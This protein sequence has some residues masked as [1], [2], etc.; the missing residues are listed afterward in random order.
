MIGKQWNNMNVT[1]YGS[2]LDLLVTTETPLTTYTWAEVVVICVVVVSLILV[3]IAGNAVVVCLV[4]INRR[5]RPVQNLFIAS[6]AVSDLCVG[7]L[8]MPLS[9]ANELMGYW[10]FGTVLCELWLAFDVLSCTASILNLCLISVDRYLCITRAMTYPRWRDKNKCVIMIGV[11][12]L[13]AMLICLPPLAGWKRPQP[14]KN[15]LPLCVL[16]SEVGYIIYSTLGSF[17]IP[18]IVM[19]S[20]YIRI[21]LAVKHQVRRRFS[22]RYDIPQ[23]P[24]HGLPQQEEIRR[25]IP[26]NE[27]CEK[28]EPMEQHE[29]EE[30]E[31]DV[32]NYRAGDYPDKAGDY[33][34]KDTDDQA[35]YPTLTDE[36]KYTTEEE[37]M[38]AT[39]LL[40]YDGE[41]PQEDQETFEG[42]IL[43]GSSMAP[44]EEDGLLQEVPD[45][46]LPQAEQG[47]VGP[48]NQQTIQ[49]TLSQGYQSA[50]PDNPEQHGQVIMPCQTHTLADTITN[51]GPEIQSNVYHSNNSGLRK[52][53]HACN[54]KMKKVQMLPPHKTFTVARL[55]RSRTPRL[56]L[57]QYFHGRRGKKIPLLH[58]DCV[59]EVHEHKK[60]RIARARERRLV[61]ILGVIMAA[62]VLCWFPFFSTYLISS[63][64]GFQVHK[65][66][67]DIFFWAGYCNSAFNPIIYTIFNR[68]IR[69]C[70]SR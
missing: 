64:T 62:F 3:I 65:T 69:L 37:E 39:A 53:S 68:D 15:G 59:T 23:P 70:K 4:V 38:P 36:E 34:D 5:M 25:F 7:L 33:P 56:N 8:I 17:F 10:C 20:V 11:V 30:L 9:L 49:D 61:L 63:I 46:L 12:W 35:T 45:V 21:Y 42:D 54:K 47:L 55:L 28:E 52:N 58:K 67:F 41:Q 44:T 43:P 40:P 57:F 31:M 1:D 50:L 18:L 60:W 24:S 51:N 29:L 2:A 14:T 27:V 16:S 13:M 22:V 26:Q 32:V 6:L 48:D 66:V 19:V